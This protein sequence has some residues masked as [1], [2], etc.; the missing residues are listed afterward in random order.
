MRHP[1]IQAITARFG[2]RTEALSYDMISDPGTTIIW[3]VEIQCP[4]LSVARDVYSEL[5][6]EA[7]RPASLPS[8]SLKYGRET[9]SPEPR[10][11]PDPTRQ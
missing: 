11:L 8:F 2:V 4:S 3:R 10:P 1:G 6:L 5:L 7:T 9:P